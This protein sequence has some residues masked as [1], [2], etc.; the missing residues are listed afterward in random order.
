[1]Q[2]QGIGAARGIAMGPALVLRAEAPT[3]SNEGQS[4]APEAIPAEMERLAQGLAQAQ[5]ALTA[6]IARSEGP[7]AEILTAHQIMLGDPELLAAAQQEIQSNRVPAEVAISRAGEAIAQVLAGLDDPYLRERA[8]DVR[9]VARQVVRVL[10]KAASPLAAL[11]RPSVIVA[12]DLAP[13]E[14]AQLDPALVLAL[15]TET[16]GPTSHTA[17][18]ARSLGIPAVVGAAN[19]LGQIEDGQMVAVDGSKG[20]VW[21]QPGGEELEQ[22]EGLLR[23]AKLEAEELKSLRNLPAITRDGHRVELAANVGHPGDS[24]AAMEAGAEGV[25]LYRTEFLFMNRGDVPTEEEQF[26]AYKAVIQAMGGRP[27]VIRTLDIGGDKE[28]PALGLEK[29]ANPFLG[30]RALRLCL[31][32]PDLFRTQLRALLRASA[33]GPTR[34]MYPMVSGLE[35]LRAA[36][37]LLNEERAKLIAEGVAV[38]TD[39]QVG[40]MIEVPSAALISDLLAPEVDFFSIG[41]NDLIQYTLAADRMNDGVAHLYQPFHPA[42]LRLIKHVCQMAHAHGKWVGMCGEMAGDPTATEVL[43]GLGLDELSMAPASLGVVKRAVCNTS[44]TEAK[45]LALRLMAGG[46]L[47]PSASPP[48]PVG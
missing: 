35:E 20:R 13:S 41:T 12:S 7:A 24:H 1:M 9:D 17:I 30:V 8:A 27:V 2:L 32:R 45:K 36:N 4:V 14:T 40:I 16:G 31:R 29:E 44:L 34:I 11:R 22:V 19:L 10:T 38:G 21:V 39:L 18:L 5:E 25:G 37:T 43:V 15:A 48:A 23:A 42:V 26:E 28:L 47:T 46:A 33:F 3:S 6:L